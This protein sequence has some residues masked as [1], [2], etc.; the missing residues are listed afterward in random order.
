MT[1]F[2]LS[3]PC[4]K[5]LFVQYQCCRSFLPLQLSF[6]PDFKLLYENFSFGQSKI[7]SVCAPKPE[8]PVLE[9]GDSGFRP[10]RRTRAHAGD[11]TRWPLRRTSMVA[12]LPLSSR[13][14]LESFPFISSSSRSGRAEL[15]PSRATASVAPADLLSPASILHAQ[16]RSTS[17]ST[18]AAPPEDPVGLLPPGIVL[19]AAGNHWRHHRSSCSASN[20]TAGCFSSPRNTQNRPLVSFSSS[21]ASFPFPPGDAVTGTR[22]RHRG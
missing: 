19:L 6:W 15:G 1:Q 20:P 22:P 8:V 14:T 18:S 16:S 10:V 9:P 7:E 21:P 4:S 3:N 2:Y 17:S 5:Q 12:Q 13:E 11:A